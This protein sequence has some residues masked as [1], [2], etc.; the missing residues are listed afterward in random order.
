MFRGEA[1][2]RGKGNGM[3]GPRSTYPGWALPNWRRCKIELKEGEQT[4]QASETQPRQDAAIWL[5]CMSMAVLFTSLGL[6][7]IFKF[8][9]DYVPGYVVQVPA[10]II[11]FAYVQRFKLLRHYRQWH[12]RGMLLLAFIVPLENTFFMKAFRKQF[13]DAYL[14][15]EIF[16][17]SILLL[18][19]LTIWTAFIARKRVL[20]HPL[21]VASFVLGL[22]GWAIATIASEYPALSLANGFFEFFCPFMVLF[23]F[24]T[25][26]PDRDFII[27][28]LR[29]F[30]IGVVLVALAQTS[31]MVREL[32]C[33]NALVLPVFADEFLEIKKNMSLMVKAGGNGYG[34]TDNLVSLL[35]L[36]LPVTVGLYYVDRCRAVW[37]TGAIALLYAGLLTYSRSGLLVIM[38]GFAAI[39]VYRLRAF[40]E[41]SA[42]PVIILVSLLAI[43]A[44]PASV[45]YLSKGIT[46]FST[47]FV[48]YFSKSTTSFSTSRT[49]T[50]TGSEGNAAK[51]HLKPSYDSSAVNRMEAW[52]RGAQ[53]ADRKSVV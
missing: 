34:N 5:F 46:S 42:L 40:R 24:A 48:E 19:T 31:A 51:R 27:H 20:L 50:G 47:A 2:M 11:G 25:N 9:P 15:L 36:A 4:L 44:P 45:E 35:T 18:L 7:L 16:R 21:I 30:L 14:G 39:V 28:S 37:A 26:T 43:H 13:L 52:M 29:L 32:C 38:I 6:P 8:F 22:T 53:I 17:P 3:D 1:T 10:I 33:G 12:L 41:L 49:G 23:L